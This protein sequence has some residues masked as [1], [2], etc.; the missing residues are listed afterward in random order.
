MAEAA[1]TRRLL[2]CAVLF[3]FSVKGCFADA[4]QTGCFQLIAVQLLDRTEDRLF[5]HLGDR[6]DAP[7]CRSRRRIGGSRRGLGLLTP[8]LDRRWQVSNMDRWTRSQCACALDAILELANVAGP[9]IREQKLES[10]V[11]D[12]ALY[13]GRARQPLEEVPHQQGN[14]LLPLP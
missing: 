13:T 5:F 3:Q 12:V 8:G 11:A 9:V 14:I 10:F 2:Q 6:H 7:Q 1:P 4:Q